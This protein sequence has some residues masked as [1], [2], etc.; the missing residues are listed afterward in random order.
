MTEKIG[1]EEL[2]DK[3]RRIAAER[4]V[5]YVYEAPTFVNEYGDPEQGEECYY[6]DPLG[7]PSCLVGMVLSEVSP[8][9]L[10]ALHSYEWEYSAYSPRCVSVGSISVGVPL[11]TLFTESALELLAH[12]QSNQDCNVPWGAAVKQAIKITQVRD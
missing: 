5:D 3:L 4:G 1:Y 12:V 11:D 8:E 10:A 9:T 2:A 7:E 6:T